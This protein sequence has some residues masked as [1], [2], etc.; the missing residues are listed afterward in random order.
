MVTTSALSSF[1]FKLFNLTPGDYIVLGLTDDD[2]DGMLEDH[3]GVG[4]Y[5]KLEERALVTVA[6]KEHVGDIDF[7]IS[8]GFDPGDETGD[9][10]GEV[11]AACQI[12]ADCQGGLYC[13]TVFEGGYCTQNCSGGTPC[14]LESE[15]F[16]LGED[17]NNCDYS[18][19]LRSC[20]SDADCRADEGYVCD[21]DQTCYPGS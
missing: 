21:A 14:P 18:I 20:A 6:A 5:P 8:P 7:T 19:C 12:S 3:E 16:C 9:G 4:V 1:D 11:G 15:C 10:S 13:E 17:S 2:N